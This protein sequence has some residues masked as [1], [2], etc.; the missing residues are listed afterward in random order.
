M[1]PRPQSPA[2][3]YSAMSAC[4]LILIRRCVNPGCIML[5]IQLPLKRPNMVDGT[6]RLYRALRDMSIQP[7]RARYVSIQIP[8]HTV[9]QKTLR[10]FSRNEYTNC[11]EITELE[12][13]VTSSFYWQTTAI[14]KHLVLGKVPL[15]TP[16]NRLL[17]SKQ[18]SGLHNTGWVL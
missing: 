2:S 7:S 1:P 8:R 14:N 17:V 6:Y 9:Q 13:R 5:S 11:T 18:L 12:R 16:L 10:V 15:L 3:R 4:T